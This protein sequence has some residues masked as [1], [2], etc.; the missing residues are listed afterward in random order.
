[1]NTQGGPGRGTS[2]RPGARAESARYALL[3]RLAPSMRHHLVVNLQPVTMIYEVIEHRLRAPEPDLASVHQSL[4]RI[5]GLT[6]AALGACDDMVSW[7]APAEGAVVGVEAGVRECASLLATSFSFRGYALR[8][9][10]G[11]GGSVPL[12][13]LRCVL[14]AA[15]LVVTDG[16]PEPADVVI[17]AEAQPDA[18][19]LVIRVV[20]CAGSRGFGSTAEYRPLDWDDLLALAEAAQVQVRRDGEGAV[21]LR[22]PQVS[23]PAFQ[24]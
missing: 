11:A 2:E 4:Q 10:V 9:E 17:S 7:L 24:A 22:L 18:T 21:R 23:E 6:R 1:M 13:G 5:N 14:S 15:L 12:P 19:E 3:R 8:N 16:H 20:P